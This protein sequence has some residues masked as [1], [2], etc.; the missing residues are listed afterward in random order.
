[1]T[2]TIQA[3]YKCGVLKPLEPIEGLEENTEVEITVS[4]EKNTFQPLLKFAGVLGE[5]EANAMMKIVDE[6]FEKV[7][8]NEWKG[9]S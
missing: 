4:T 6:E 7:D 9:L 1:M 2:K 3:L 8:M 5:E